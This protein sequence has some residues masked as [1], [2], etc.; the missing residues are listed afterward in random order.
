MEQELKPF[1]IDPSVIEDFKNKLP[2]FEKK[3][4]EEVKD[5][6]W[7]AKLISL[8]Q[9]SD[10][11][12]R[13]TILFSYEDYFFEKEL[14][15]WCEHFSKDDSLDNEINRH[16]EKLNAYQEALN[17]IKEIA[18]GML[19]KSLEYTDQWKAHLQDIVEIDP[20]TTK[21]AFLFYRNDM[22]FTKEFVILYDNYHS[23]DYY[24]NILAEILKVLNT[25]I[26]PTLEYYQNLIT[27]IIY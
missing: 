12:A 3:I 7:S 26:T 14:K 27:Q 2:D 21:L 18:N 23:M 9:E 11:V 8:K 24:L 16:L 4:E 25:P 19:G 5:R 20:L 13:A 10:M 1:E 22:E 17:K 6:L 15:L